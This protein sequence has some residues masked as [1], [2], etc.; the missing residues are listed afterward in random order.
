MNLFSEL[1]NRNVIR[2]AIAYAA[3]G[4]LLVEVGSVVLPAFGAP[5]WALRGLIILVAAGFIPALVLFWRYE[6]TPE[7]VMTESDAEAARTDSQLRS[8]R[9]DFA[10]MAVLAVTL[11]L[12]IAERLTLD[13]RDSS[14]TAVGLAVLPFENLS[15]S[16]EDAYIVGMHEE[17]LSHLARVPEL[18]LISRTSVTRVAQAGLTVPE[19]G[20]RLDVS[21]VLE[22]SLRRAGDRVRITVQLIDAASDEHL[23]AENFERSLGDLFALQSDV[24]LAIA[25]QLHRELSTDT[26]AAITKTPTAD[27]RAYQLYLQA[28]DVF[29]GKRMLSN[30]DAEMIEGLLEQALA[31]DPD[32]L[33]AK[34]FLAQALGHSPKPGSDERALRLV[35]EIRQ[36]WPDH[37]LALRALGSYRYSVEHDYAGALEAYQSV[38]AQ[39]PNDIV[40]IVNVRSAYKRLDRRAE[41]LYWSRRAVE[42]SPE[43][44][45][46][47]NEHVDALLA[48]RRLEEVLE[49]IDSSAVRFPE[50]D[51]WKTSAAD[52]RLWLFGDVKAYL[53]AGERLR[54]E[55]LWGDLSDLSWIYY[56]RGDLDLALVHLEARRGEEYHF[57]S[58]LA[59]MDGAQILRLEG[60]D[61]EAQAMAERAFAHL[62]ESAEDVLS[63]SVFGREYVLIAAQA[64]AI[65]G[66]NEEANRLRMLAD[67]QEP[68][69]FFWLEARVDIEHAYLDAYLGDPR[70]GWERFEQWADD[71]FVFATRAY[72]RVSP[73]H[74]LLFGADSRFQ[75]FIND[76]G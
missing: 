74:Q 42:L 66:K 48:N 21:H 18:R 57:E 22:G 30:A 61:E 49:F 34:A 54:D 73:H 27:P 75:E 69:A 60:R 45:I 70:T 23:W 3:L 25:T 51:S 20:R 2:G 53:E 1:K 50:N 59:D 9:I 46:L 7:G 68:H 31:L 28:I 72:L 6:W 14:S 71:P 5:E 19:I 62:S 33:Q 8:R 64:A 17:L 26:I 52:H 39:L 12:V 58:A 40:S 63:Q 43:S 38:V 4:W 41:F 15:A 16:D 67:Q 11:A 44:Q 65:A 24:A 47:A 76:E 32:F 29:R 13:S 55:G 36:R 37:V 10:I 35:S 56:D